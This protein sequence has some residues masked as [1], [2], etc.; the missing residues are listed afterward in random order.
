MKMIQDS[1]AGGL[2]N[3]VQKGKLTEATAKDQAAKVMSQITS[4][5]DV[6]AVHQ[7]DL[8]VEAIVEVRAGGDLGGEKAEFGFGGWMGVFH[9]LVERV[10]ADGELCCLLVACLLGC[11]TWRSRR[12]SS[13]TWA[14]TQR[15][16]R[17]L[18]PTHPPSLSLSWCV[19]V[20]A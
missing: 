18:A 3:E 7:C 19:C 13:V 1:L 20:C 12:S 16:M 11:R 6:A 15:M 4:S 10:R 14:R 5:G 8:I 9:R 17:F 2:K